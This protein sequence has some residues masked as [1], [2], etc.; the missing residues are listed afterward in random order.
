MP[1]NYVDLKKLMEMKVKDI[2]N[3]KPPICKPQT[4]VLDL[5]KKLRA[6]KEDYVLVIDKTKKLHGIVTESDVLYA[7][8]RPSRHMFVGAW[9]A[10]EM[11]KITAS[12]VEDIMSK[13]PLT[14][15]PEMSLREALDTM[16]T[17]KFRHLPVLENN[18]VVG[19]LTIQDIMTALLK[20][21]K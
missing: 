2:I 13:H 20:L 15:H 6:Q 11:G 1:R 18:K 9:A 4:S 3:R 12:K 8:K 7:L 17:H 16:I 14:V 5:L 21:S 10:K 19:A